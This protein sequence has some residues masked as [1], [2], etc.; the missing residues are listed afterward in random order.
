MKL[1][2]LSR[3]DTNK[4]REN[5]ETQ[6]FVLQ[7][8]EINTEIVLQKQKWTRKKHETIAEHL[9]SVLEKTTHVEKYL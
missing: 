7:N 3:K 9:I 5:Y 2:K 8:N 4:Q 1:K 6:K